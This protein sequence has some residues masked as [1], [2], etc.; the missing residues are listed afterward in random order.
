M[1]TLLELIDPAA[2]ATMRHLIG[3]AVRTQAIYVAA[4]LGI[5]DHLSLGP[6]SADELAARVNA[7]APTL[8]R[9]LRFL[10]ASGVFV[11]HEDGR[12]ALNR[13]AE[14][15]QTAHPRSMRPSAIRAGEG[16]WNVASR[17]LSAVQ[18]GTT[19]HAE[20]HGAS[21]FERSEAATFDARMSFSTGGIAESLAKLETVA[22]AKR[23]V[24]VGGGNGAMLMRLLDARPDLEGVLFDRAATID[25]ARGRVGDRCELVAGDFF[26]SIP[27]GDV[28]LLSW[29][30]HDWEDADALRILRACHG[31]DVVIVEVL[32]P[33]QAKETAPVPGVL[34]DPYTLD[35]QMLML[36]GGRERTLSEYR[37]LLRDAGF[38]V[39]NVTLLDSYRGASAIEARSLPISRETAHSDD[40]E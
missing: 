36:T 32:M 3:G 8:R 38:E 37:A 33:E 9:V 25:A 34:A 7:H 31:G 17:L 21:F 29:I 40:Q 14:F 28:Y 24:D 26:E 11:E 15:L 30:L 13:T 18:N 27:R 20:V 19:P 22:R 6:R 12:F 2:E 5:P 39:A 1:R 23:V 10:V 4:K 35:L 16:M